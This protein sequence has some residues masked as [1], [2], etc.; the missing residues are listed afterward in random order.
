MKQSFLIFA[1]L[2]LGSQANASN[3]QNFA[4]VYADYKKGAYVQAVQKLEAIKGS[5]SEM[6]TNFYWRGLCYSRLQKFDLAQKN[7]K[8]ALILGTESEDIYYEIGQ[9][10]YA[11][12]N[13]DEAIKAFK[14]SISLNYKTG[15]SSYYAGYMHQILE[16]QDTALKYYREI[17]KLKDDPDK[18]KQPALFQEAEIYFGRVLQKYADD[19]SKRNSALEYSVLPRYETTI[20]Y[21]GKT[22]TADQAR[23]RLNEIKL[24]YGVPGPKPWSA[25]I[26]QKIK[27]DSNI[28]TEA[29]EATVTISDT[30]SFISSTRASGGYTYNLNTKLSIRPDAAVSGDYH[31]QRGEVRVFTNDQIAAD[32]NVRAKNN[33]LIKGKPATL[34]FDVESNYTIRDKDKVHE[35]PFYARHL[36][37]VLGDKAFFTPIGST[38]LKFS[39]KIYD[40]YSTP[41]DAKTFG[42]SISQHLALIEFTRLTI[43]P[44]VDFK[45]AEDGDNNRNTYK[46]MTSFT[47]PEL[48][49][50]VTLN[51]SF[52]W[53]IDNT[54]NVFESRGLEMTYSASLGTSFK[55][56]KNINGMLNY[57]YTKKTSK[58]KATYAYTKH[59][60]TLGATYNF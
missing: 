41:L 12:Q 23:S 21:D 47:V 24:K 44:S 37:F 7:Y 20:D 50:R 31:F 3:K 32:V 30:S 49:S 19:K 2:L 13:I 35:L 11:S 45:R 39:Y 57:D 38:T 25:S 6:A 4:E 5:K 1:F 58:D 14:K 59:V 26:A 40:S 54:M 34:M 48:I 16:K 60:I 52:T 55:F 51:P 10:E 43:A 46:I 28:V 53:T 22:S 56:T 15:T 17:Q 27:W 42:I 33:H 9:A 18:V 36:K 29:D 8:K